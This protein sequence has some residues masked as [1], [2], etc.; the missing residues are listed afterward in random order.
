[1]LKRTLVTSL[2][3]SVSMFL[4]SAGQARPPIATVGGTNNSG[5]MANVGSAKCPKGVAQI[6]GTA[7]VFT[8]PGYCGLVSISGTGNVVNVDRAGRIE[9]SGMANVVQYRYLNPDPSK[10]G[11]MAHPTKSAGGMTNVIQWTQGKDF[12]SPDDSSN[13]E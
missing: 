1:M 4:V 8:I 13:D 11:K 6:S 3:L 5:G 7:N 10:K 12:Y 9:V 2:C